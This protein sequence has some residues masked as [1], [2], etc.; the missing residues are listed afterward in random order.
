M[1]KMTINIT[2]ANDNELGYTLDEIKRNVE[3]GNL[4]GM[5]SREDGITKYD[6]EINEEIISTLGV[7]INEYYDKNTVEGMY[8]RR[9]YDFDNTGEYRTDILINQEYEKNYYLD[10]CEKLN[11]KS[12]E[13]FTKLLSN[14]DYNTILNIHSSKD[15]MKL[16]EY[17]NILNDD[18]VQHISEAE[19][20][21]NILV[22][23]TKKDFKN[24]SKM[25]F[26]HLKRKE[27]N[28]Y[29]DISR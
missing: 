11:I 1:L 18:Q 22:E 25:K 12:N 29:I 27:K 19:E 2:A 7:D 16:F 8:E 6:F 24:H 5:D 3:N 15:I 13:K 4:I 20:D 9:R 26:D 10:V 23:E 28:K 21:L 14:E 17:G